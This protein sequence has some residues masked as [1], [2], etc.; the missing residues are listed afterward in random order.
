MTSRP[1][2]DEEFLAMVREM[3][4][5]ATKPCGCGYPAQPCL[6]IMLRNGPPF[7]PRPCEPIEASAGGPSA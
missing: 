3:R 7:P 5:P 4:D 1:E 2:N 6:R